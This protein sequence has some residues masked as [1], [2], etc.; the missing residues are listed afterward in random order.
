MLRSI[1]G[2]ER[3]TAGD[4]RIDGHP[5]FDAENGVFVPPDQRPIAMVFQSYAIWPHMD[6][7]ENIAFPLR[8]G[9]LKMDKEAVAGSRRREYSRCSGSTP[10]RHGR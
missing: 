7:F 1:A 5:I 10:W 3:P 2:L 4:I 9:R 6:V 8:R